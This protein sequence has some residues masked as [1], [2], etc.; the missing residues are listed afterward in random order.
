MKRIMIVG[1]PGSGKSTLA[2]ELG[3]CLTL[4]VVHVDHIH[5]QAGWIERSRAQ[6]E[7]LCSEAHAEDTWIFEGG[8]SSTWPE[9]LD[10]ADTLIWLDFPLTVRAWRVFRRTIQHYGRTRPDLPD[11]C[12]ERFDLEFTKWIWNTRHSGKARM[13][14]LFDCA[15][16]SKDKYWL[17]NQRQVNDFISTMIS[18]R[19]V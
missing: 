2:R 9:R 4:P 12:P 6:K 13:R 5:W 19:S 18:D 14:K 15:P 3:E 7:R 8:Q 10:R 1:Q 11:G 16:A 17:K